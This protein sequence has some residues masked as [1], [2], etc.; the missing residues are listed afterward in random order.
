MK[1]ILDN[2]Y[3]YPQIQT[4]PDVWIQIT[5]PNEFQPTG[6]YNIG[7]TAGIETDLCSTPWIEGCN[8]MNLILTSSD[9]SK[10][11]FQASRFE[12][13]NQAGQ[14]IGAIELKTPVEILFEGADLNKYFPIPVSD[15][16]TNPGLLPQNPGW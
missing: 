15:L 12:Q 11:V 16:M 14:P 6:K 10:K 3:P 2:I 4:Q 1:E 13:R 5:V 8:R 9:H 7:I